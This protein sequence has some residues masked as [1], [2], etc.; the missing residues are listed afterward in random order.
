M[1]RQ[2]ARQG[3]VLLIPVKSPT[4]LTEETPDGDRVVLA[5]GEAT[6]HVHAVSAAR[7]R[8]WRGADEM[9]YLEVR[10]GTQLIHDEHFPVMLDE[11]WYEIRRQREYVPAALPRTVTD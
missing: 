6:G 4:G 2:Q 11:G 1:A 7:A 8:A 3:D 9:R 5:H 10:R